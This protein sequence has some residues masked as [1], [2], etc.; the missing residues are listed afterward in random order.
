MIHGRG[1]KRDIHI[2]NARIEEP[3][4]RAIPVPIV[5]MSGG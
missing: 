3:H 2:E 1:I 5:G 4:V